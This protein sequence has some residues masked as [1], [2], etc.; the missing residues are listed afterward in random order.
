LRRIHGHK[1][2]PKHSTGRKQTPAEPRIYRPHVA[3]KP[4]NFRL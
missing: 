3:T 2:T 1:N 4:G